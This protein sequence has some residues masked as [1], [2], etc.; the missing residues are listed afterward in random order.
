MVEIRHD[1]DDTA[2]SKSAATNH[3][4]LDTFYPTL[5]RNFPQSGNAW[6]LALTIGQRLFFNDQDTLTCISTLSTFK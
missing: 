6:S 5:L 4:S 3:T 1:P 2:R